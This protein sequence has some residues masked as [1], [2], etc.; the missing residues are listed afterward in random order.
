MS[1][2]Q[3]RIVEAL[4]K[5]RTTFV[6]T[7]ESYYGIPAASLRRDIQSLRRQGYQI[8]LDGGQVTLANE[9]Q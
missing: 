5:Y 6:S 9:R 8:T 4:R 1:N 2:R 3:A 7:F